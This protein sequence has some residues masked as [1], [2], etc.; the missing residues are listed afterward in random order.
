[1]DSSNDLIQNFEQTFYRHKT[2]V[3]NKNPFNF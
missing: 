2:S 1:M 3:T